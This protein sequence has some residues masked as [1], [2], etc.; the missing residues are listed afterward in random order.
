MFFIYNRVKD[1]PINNFSDEM[2]CDPNAYIQNAE[3]SSNKSCND[4][5]ACGVKVEQQGEPAKVL[6][7][8]SYN[9]GNFNYDK[10]EG[11]PKQ[12]QTSQ[13][14]GLGSIFS[15]ILQN[16]P[17]LLKNIDIGKIT[18]LLSGFKGEKKEGD[19]KGLLGGLNLQS[20]IKT[21]SENNALGDMLKNLSGNSATGD[22]LKNITGNNNISELIKI[23]SQ[24]GILDGF[25]KGFGNKK[26]SEKEESISTENADNID[27]YERVDQDP[28]EI[29]IEKPE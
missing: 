18:S 29:I 17:N 9:T 25:L 15:N 5:S 1:N 2:Y 27:K 14:S 20:L 19:S 8:Q 12:P 22:M 13:G 28:T 4:E 6:Y 7:P 21:F 16:I 24:S 10:A 23:V 11:A 26:S 3:F